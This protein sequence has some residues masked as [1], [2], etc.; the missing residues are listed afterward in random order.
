MLQKEHSNPDLK[1]K[2]DR[3][4]ACGVR[5]S[6]IRWWWD[7]PPL[8]RV[9]LERADLLNRMQLFLTVLQ[10]GGTPD[11][12]GRAMWHAHPRF[13]ELN[14]QEGEDG[15]LPIEL[16]YR[17]VEFMERHPDQCRAHARDQSRTFNA[18]VRAKIR[19]GLL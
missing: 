2:L 12:A 11:E 8:E 4:R 3:L 16:K 17:I 15:P 18:F 6:D 1:R 10:Q 5:D 9:L 14:E 7:L 13:D 19:E